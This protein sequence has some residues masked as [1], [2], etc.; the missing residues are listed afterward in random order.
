VLPYWEEKLVFIGMLSTYERGSEI[1]EYLYGRQISDTKL[2]RITESAGEQSEQILGQMDEQGDRVPQKNKG[3]CTY[4]MVDGSMILT[5]EAGWKEVKLG[6]IFRMPKVEEEGNAEKKREH[7]LNHSEY[8]SHIGGREEFE[9]KVERLLSGSWK[10]SRELIFVTDGARWQSKWIN[11]EYPQAIQILDFYHAMENISKY[12]DTL[13]L[14]KGWKE[15]VCNKVGFILKNEGVDAALEQ[16][17]AIPGRRTKCHKK[18]KE[19]LLQYIE[20][21]RYRMNYPKYIERGYM[22]GSGPIESAHR[23]IIQKRM[24]LS[25]QRWSIKGA[26]HM[27]NLRTIY[28][29]GH[30]DK[31]I[32]VFKRAS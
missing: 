24:K 22:I 4:A 9:K 11:R 7:G 28:M 20:S 8:I 17:A 29:S 27:L 26:Q 13:E 10:Q 15:Q 21:N 18:A 6:R 19:K 16:L 25:G 5:R 30:W 23:T 14:K 31:M 2:Y 32:P 12:V 1:V 3:E